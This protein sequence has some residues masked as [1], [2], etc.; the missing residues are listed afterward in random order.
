[1][2]KK[3]TPIHRMKLGDFIS[4]TIKEIIDGVSDAQQYAKEKDAEINPGHVNWSDIKRAYFKN[5]KASGEDEAQGLTPID[6]DILITIGDS[7]K[8][9]GGVGVFAASLGLGA[10]GEAKDYSETVNR[11]KFQILTKLPQQK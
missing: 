7:D 4:Q 2:F 1:M 9:E 6:F 3:D 11:I 8:I 10:K 5:V